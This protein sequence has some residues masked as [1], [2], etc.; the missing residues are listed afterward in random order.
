MN[1]ICLF[2]VSYPQQ[3][4]LFHLF[5]VYEKEVVLVPKSGTIVVKINGVTSSYKTDTPTV[6][7]DMLQKEK[8]EMEKD[9]N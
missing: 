2:Y 8:S 3:L 6:K 7:S 4:Q 5:L 1:D 9:I